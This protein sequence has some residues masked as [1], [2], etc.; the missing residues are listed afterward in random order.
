MEKTHH[1][2]QEKTLILKWATRD[3]ENKEKLCNAQ[4]WVIS[5]EPHTLCRQHFLLGDL[6]TPNHASLPLQTPEQT[7]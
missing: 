5:K 1:M 2:K 7:S 4:C 3:Q 6:L